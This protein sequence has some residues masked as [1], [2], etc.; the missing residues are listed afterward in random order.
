MEDQ[1]RNFLFS[2]LNIR[3][4]HLQVAQAWQAMIEDRHYTPALQTLLGELTAMAILLAKGMKHPGRLTLQVQGKGPVSLLMVEVTDQL[5]LRGVAKTR[6]A[7]EPELA[8]IHDLL[9]DGQIMITLE[10]TVTNK[11]F[12]SYVLRQGD[13]V[14]ECFT[15]YLSQSD[16]LPSKLWLAAN[17]HAIAGLLIQKMPTTDEQDADGWERIAALSDTVGSEELLTL[18]AETLLHRLF[19]EETVRLY[20]P[21]TVAYECP[22]DREKVKEMIRSL[23]EEEARRV[24]EQEGEIV[25]HNEVCNFHERF[26]LADIEALFHPTDESTLKH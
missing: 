13:T 4:Q 11:L 6:G 20:E 18:P 14:A 7:I 8:G 24:I 1:A 22:R 19:H 17:E 15:H 26:D 2:E 10:N 9:G 25:V 5:Q 23:G 3:G 21:S 12:Q 16:Q